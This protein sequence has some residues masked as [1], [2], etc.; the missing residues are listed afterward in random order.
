M[1]CHFKVRFVCLLKPSIAL[2]LPFDGHLVCKHDC[3]LC[4]SLLILWL[5]FKCTINFSLSI[6]ILIFKNNT[7]IN[8]HN[9]K[10]LSVSLWC[11]VYF[12]KMIL[13]WRRTPDAFDLQAGKTN[14]CLTKSNN[15]FSVALLIEVSAVESLWLN[16][17]PF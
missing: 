1:G 2:R 8:T 17:P 4:A 10:E 11:T 9:P 6:L 15:L 5:L 13:F 14:T 3:G 12:W 16:P 7:Y